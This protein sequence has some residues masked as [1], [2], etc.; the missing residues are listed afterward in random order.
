MTTSDYDPHEHADRLGL[1]I[2]YQPLRTGFGLYVPGRDLI[3]LRPRLKVATERSVLAHEIAHHL[4]AHR[5]TTGVWSLRQERQADLTAA[6]N[7]IP[8]DRLRDVQ[9]FSPDP[10]E[11]CRE[12]GVTRDLLLAYIRAA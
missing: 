2:V 12:L 10:A 5:K 8:P 3:M 9:L 6:R 4:H 7:L 11:W 1:T